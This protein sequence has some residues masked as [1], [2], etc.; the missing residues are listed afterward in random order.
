MHLG[1]CRLVVEEL[2]IGQHERHPADH[3]LACGAA[4][5]VHARRLPDPGHTRP[6]HRKP[7]T[8]L[9]RCQHCVTTLHVPAGSM[10]TD[11]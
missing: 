8:A 6:E 2:G 1:A 10:W 11:A 9:A 7:D 3:A 5:P 4:G